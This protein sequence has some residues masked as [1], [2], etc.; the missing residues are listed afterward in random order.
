[1][2][3]EERGSEAS[4]PADD[5]PPAGEGDPEVEALLSEVASARAP[6]AAQDAEDS[7]GA[8]DPGDVPERSGTPPEELAAFAA[9]PEDG[10]HGGGGSSQPA[11]SPA[12]S[13]EGA[14]AILGSAPANPYAHLLTIRGDVDSTRALALFLAGVSFFLVAY[15][16]LT[17]SSVQ[18]FRVT[19]RV[20]GGRIALPDP[21]AEWI[22]SDGPDYV[23]LEEGRPQAPDQ[24]ARDGDALVFHP[25]AEGHEV[26]FRYRVGHEPVLS[27]FMFPP[28]GD[29]LRALAENVAG[30]SF[31]VSCPNPDCP[32]KAE[33]V[34]VVLGSAAGEALLAYRAPQEGEPAP[35]GVTCP[36]C[37]T[38]LDGAIAVAQ[39]PYRFRNG[40]LATVGRTSA[41]FLI[42]AAI[43]LPLGLLAGAFPPIKRFIS[44]VEIAG[45]YTPPVALVP[46]GAAA[47]GVLNSS[48]FLP[49]TSGEIVRIGFLVLFTSLW[50]YPLTVKEIE[51]VDDVYIHTAYTLG[52]SR[53]QVLTRVLFPVAA[54]KIWQHLR[55]SFGIGWAL[56]L[57]AEGYMVPR[58]AGEAGIGL[59]MVD[60]QRRALMANYFSALVA[61]VATGVVFDTLFGFVGR[62]LFPY[63][64]VS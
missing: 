18:E 46:L 16:L 15:A 36:R 19:A 4:P 1:M 2:G 56:I 57:L 44:P 50:L 21:T 34:P 5:A 61:I 25:Q 48:G 10:P 51:D 23:F 47:Y 30:D 14:T 42:A 12:P 58:A 38:S 11:A 64:E 17:Y 63:Q 41:G 53:R 43:C 9:A 37:G 55:V 39:P 8:Q 45:G 32:S 24:F 31:H 20:E 22:R 6:D 3:E 29:L 28:L 62:R 35:T 27:P 59:F 7:G 40:L 49:D 26:T 54:G 52:A 13:V 33:G 60:M